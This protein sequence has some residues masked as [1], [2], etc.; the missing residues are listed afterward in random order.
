MLSVKLRCSWG[1]DR[2]CSRPP[3]ALFNAVTWRSG[4]GTMCEEC[5]ILSASKASSFALSRDSLDWCRSWKTDKDRESSL[6]RLCTQ[7]HRICCAMSCGL[8]AR[9]ITY[10]SRRISKSYPHNSKSFSPP[11]NP[12]FLTTSS[13]AALMSRSFCGSTSMDVTV[14][15]GPPTMLSCSCSFTRAS[16]AIVCVAPFC[17]SALGDLRQPESTPN[18]SI[19]M[20]S[21]AAMLFS[22]MVPHMD[23]MQRSAC[24]DISMCLDLTSFRV[25][26]NRPDWNMRRAYLSLASHRFASA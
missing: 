8:S 20:E 11:R 14:R 15:S 13:A 22:G 16:C 19:K 23:E 24:R 3:E 4:G 7:S 21:F 6:N 5:R 2:G 17:S 9:F 25:M 12:R 1:M 26:E 10:Q 18:A